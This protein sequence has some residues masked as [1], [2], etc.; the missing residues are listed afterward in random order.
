MLGMCWSLNVNDAHA[1]REAR[2]AA[3]SSLA[4]HTKSADALAAAELI[5]GEL[6]SNA[7]RHADG[8]VCLQISVE[9]GHAQISVHDTSAVFAMDFRRPPNHFS[10]SGRGLYIISELARTVAVTPLHGMGKRVTV[11]LDLP[12]EN[13]KAF[14]PSCL[15]QW[16]QHE[17]GVCMRPRISRFHPDGSQWPSD[18]T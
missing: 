1:A 12:V 8:Y 3:T 4:E 6:L 15:R 11:T 18:A 16:L 17:S 7:A 10:E 13:T 5:I 14:A 2:K 9:A